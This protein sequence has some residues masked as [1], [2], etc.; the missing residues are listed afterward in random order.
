[1]PGWNAC[2]ERMAGRYDL[3]LKNG[4]RKTQSVSRLVRVAEAGERAKM[5]ALILQ[6]SF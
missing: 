6:P 4:K 1:M 3:V 5:V 2:C